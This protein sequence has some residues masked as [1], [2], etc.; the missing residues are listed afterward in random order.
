MKI[1]VIKKLKKRK[2]EK[3]LEAGLLK[4]KNFLLE[5]LR[6]EWEKTQRQAKREHLVNL[7]KDSSIVV[8]KAL[9]V[10]LAISGALTVAII[11]PNIF[12]AVGR[13][14]R[15]RAF[16]S[17]KG[18]NRDKDYLKRQ[19]Y[20]EISRNNESVEIKLT[21]RGMTQ[22]L[23]RGFDEIKLEKPER[24]DGFWRVVIFDIPDKH[25]WA[26]EA[27]R[28]RLKFMEFFQ[29]QKSVFVTPYPCEK[30][31]A[32]C[33]S[34]FSISHHIRLLKTRDLSNDVELMK[35]FKLRSKGDASA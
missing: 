11:A 14:T 19:R 17:K 33:T 28:D 20:V 16:L 6:N 10:L 18:F 23:K 8:G 27:F 29:L 15:H 22:C 9:L 1:G 25:K 2:Y 35:N 34:L 21:E 31:I 32:F 3:K 5:R 26:R 24:W 4:N 12:G 30:E 7:A 13:S